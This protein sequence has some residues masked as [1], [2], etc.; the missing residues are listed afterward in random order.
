MSKPFSIVFL[1]ILLWSPN[2]LLS[3][4]PSSDNIVVIGSA[5]IEVPADQVVIRISLEYADKVDPK[6]AFDLH[7]AAEAKLVSLLR[8]TRIPDSLISY[9]LLNM[10]QR[11]EYTGTSNPVLVFVTN[12][13]VTVTLNDVSRY[14]AFYLDLLN[15]GFSALR[16][17]FQSS[18]AIEAQRDAL[19]KAILQARSKAELMARLAG[20]K[21]SRISRV[22]DTEET[23]PVIA[24]Y[25][26]PYIRRPFSASTAVSSEL[27]SIPQTVSIGKQ[28]KVVFDLVR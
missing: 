21:I 4:Q 28:V 13:T 3:Q 23:E 5:L 2:P 26:A 1:T 27:A 14:I 15:N 24:R 6:S 17:E 19:E 20:R 10:I 9:S 8:T 11:P 22:A 12:Q 25:Y 16:A 18:R 7:K